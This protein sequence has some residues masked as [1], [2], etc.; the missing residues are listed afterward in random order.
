MS[1]VIQASD[2]KVAVLSNAN[3][4]LKASVESKVEAAT[5]LESKVE[6]LEAQ[7]ASLKADKER[8]ITA[9][10]K[11]SERNKNYLETKNK[12]ISEE[13]NKNLVYEQK[14]EANTNILSTLKSELAET[15]S[16]KKS[17]EKETSVLKQEVDSLKRSVEASQELV[18]SYQQA[19]A[20]VIAGA[21]GVQLSN[22]PV[23]ATT[24]VSELQ[25]IICGGTSTSGIPA[26]PHVNDDIIESLDV[27]EDEDGIITI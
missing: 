3:R 20:D 9:N 27:V 10:T 14:I 16:A 5:S 25:D 11:L 1:K 6:R 15:V 4:K 19:Y 2:N 7:V 21:A 18:A 24:S 13:K 26:A 12:I 22:I 8:L 23:T 17:A